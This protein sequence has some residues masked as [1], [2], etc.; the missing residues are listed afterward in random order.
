MRRPKYID[1][2]RARLGNPTLLFVVNYIRK[3]GPACFSYAQFVFS[4]PPPCSRQ[5][6]GMRAVHRTFGTYYAFAKPCL[7]RGERR[8]ITVRARKVSFATVLPVAGSSIASVAVSVALEVRVI[9]I[10]CAIRWIRGTIQPP[11]TYL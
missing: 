10:L 8:R 4:W 2:M 6:R 11:G 5:M 3:H 9:G 1:F 7:S